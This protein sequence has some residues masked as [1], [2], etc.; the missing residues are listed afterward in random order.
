MTDLLSP[1][2]FPG[3]FPFTFPDLFLIKAFS[4]FSLFLSLNLPSAFPRN[5][6]ERP[7]SSL[8]CYF[9]ASFFAFIERVSTEAGNIPG[10]FSA[11]FSV[12]SSSLG[13]STTLGSTITFSPAKSFQSI[14]DIP[15]KGTEGLIPITILPFIKLDLIFTS[16]SGTS[17][18]P[19]STPETSTFAPV[20]FSVRGST[21][22]NMRD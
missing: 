12:F 10:N 2:C 6:P 22:S 7:V 9:M 4:A 3:M 13:F 18:T 8:P 5:V 21:L 1:S 11:N 14:K 16:W 19:I 20:N 15:S 17:K